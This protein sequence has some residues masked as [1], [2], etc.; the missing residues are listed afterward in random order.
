MSPHM[1]TCARTAVVAAVAVAGLSLAACGGHAGAAAPTGSAAPSTSVPVSTPPPPP[2]PPLSPLTGLPPAGAPV[3]AVKVDNV[4]SGA[5]SGLNDADV[6]YCELVEGG[7]TRLLAVFASHQPTSVGP[8]RSARATDVELLGQYGR[9]ALAFSGA[10]AAVVATVRAANLQDDIYDGH[11][12]L[13]LFDR[14]RPAPYQ[15]L[16]DVAK[17]VAAAPGDAAQDIGFRFGPAPAAPPV[18]VT[19]L[20]A[21]YPA[22]VVSASWDAVSSSWLMSRDGHPQMLSDGTQA[23]ATNILVQYVSN[24]GAAIP[25]SKTVGTGQAVLFRGGARYDGTWSRASLTAP[26]T[27]TAASGEPLTLSPGRTW[28]LLLPASASL[29][30][31]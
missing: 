15:F 19:T 24:D 7:L 29:V 13:Y 28:V 3:V 27:W 8:V 4:S 23:S 20:T 26:T 18:P 12:D 5:Q 21:R 14:S 10:N 30:A 25:T 1:P 9:I 22:A 6:V 17:A 2:P 16:V 31:Q 11:P